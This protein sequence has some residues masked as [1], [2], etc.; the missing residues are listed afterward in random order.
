MF[1]RGPSQILDQIQSVSLRTTIATTAIVSYSTRWQPWPPFL[2]D[3]FL[4][5]R[6]QFGFLNMH[7][8]HPRK[9]ATKARNVLSAI[10]RQTSRTWCSCGGNGT[11][12]HQLAHAPKGDGVKGRSS[13][14][15]GQ[16]WFP[17][18]PLYRAQSAGDIYGESYSSSA[19]DST[20]AF[21]SPDVVRRLK[22]KFN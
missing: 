22:G 3:P 4:S 12:I 19:H 9:M 16:G 14:G 17:I 20:R 10:S 13:R 11:V 5:A 18:T 1:K 7:I 8:P 15:A 6:R 2:P 21:G